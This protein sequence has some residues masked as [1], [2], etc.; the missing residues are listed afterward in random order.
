[1]K[2]FRLDHVEAAVS[3]DFGLLYLGVSPIFEKATQE[4]PPER[5]SA[6]EFG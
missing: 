6:E 4:D 2:V 3:D 1:M 5:R